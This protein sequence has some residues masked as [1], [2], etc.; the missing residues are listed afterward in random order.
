[1]LIKLFMINIYYC[2]VGSIH[3][4]FLYEVPSICSH[5]SM[6]EGSKVVSL[7]VM[8][9]RAM[10]VQ[11]NMSTATRLCLKTCQLSRMFYYPRMVL[12]HDSI[13]IR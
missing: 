10:F 6:R 7:Y 4:L 2:R 8:V 5:D 9:C 11:R 12:S 3:Y 13:F 1:M